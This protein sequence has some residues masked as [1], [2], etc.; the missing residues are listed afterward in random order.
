MVLVPADDAAGEEEE[1]YCGT[2]LNVYS[3]EYS[4]RCVGLGSPFSRATPE[5]FE[6]RITLLLTHRIPP[7]RRSIAANSVRL[8]S[9]PIPRKKYPKPGDV[10][11]GVPPD[12]G[13]TSFNLAIA[14]EN[15][16]AHVS[17]QLLT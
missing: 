9:M 12:P 6:P 17:M 10:M 16:R 3:A 11:H 15:G 5:F 7:R 4:K 2:Q 13:E 8:L 14:V 1:E